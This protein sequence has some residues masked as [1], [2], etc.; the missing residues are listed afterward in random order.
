MKEEKIVDKYR[1]QIRLL[2]IMIFAV[3]ILC[4]AGYAAMEIMDEYHDDRDGDDDDHKYRKWFKNDREDWGIR[5][6]DNG[7]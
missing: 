3:M 1:K 6:M 5:N 2:L 4:I 7:I